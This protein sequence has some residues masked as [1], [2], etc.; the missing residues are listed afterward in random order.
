MRRVERSHEKAASK[1][2]LV[3]RE[4]LASKQNAGANE[5][6]EHEALAA[7]PWLELAAEQQI[8]SPLRLACVVEQRSEFDR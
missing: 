8:K 1:P 5:L 7:F 3:V 4:G 2:R 6:R